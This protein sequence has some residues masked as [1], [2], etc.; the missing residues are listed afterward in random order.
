MQLEKYEVR[1]SAR[2]TGYMFVSVGEQGSIIKVVEYTPTENPDEYNLGFGDYDPA[3]RS[4]SDTVKSNNGD[5]D[6]VLATI[7]ATAI[8][9]LSWYPETTIFAVGS[10]DARTRTYQMG[11]SRFYNEIELEYGVFGLRDG[12]WEVFEPNRSYAAFKMKRK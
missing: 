8:D 11:I 9:F 4:V 2:H 7:G 12:H 3:T 1:S 6:K 10:T 5:R